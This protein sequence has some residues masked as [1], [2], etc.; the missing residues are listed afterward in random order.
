[1]IEKLSSK[2]QLFCREYMLDLNA[3]QAA[4]RA[5]YSKKT[6]RQQGQRLLT[7]VDIKREIKMMTNEK[8][9]KL[10]IKAEDVLNELKYLGINKKV[11][12]NKF[13]YHNKIKALE[14]LGKYFGMFDKRDT[15]DDYEIEVVRR[16]IK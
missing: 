10:D 12:G 2:K 3:T 13:T 14:M 6:A 5:G 9:E 7:N 15:G 11:D 1:M 16:V 8:Q 4:I